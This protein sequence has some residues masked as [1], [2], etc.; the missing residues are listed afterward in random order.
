LKLTDNFIQ[1]NSHENES[2]FNLTFTFNYR[3]G[4]VQSRLNQLIV[5]PMH[6]HSSISTVRDRV[7]RPLTKVVGKPTNSYNIHDPR[8]LLIGS[9]WREIDPEPM[10]M[11]PHSIPLSADLDAR[12]G[13]K[14]EMEH[15]R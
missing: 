14:K 2:S 3:R 5:Q 11:P 15:S 12:R 1:P 8:F 6:N 9:R 10:L 13:E 7:R 4:A